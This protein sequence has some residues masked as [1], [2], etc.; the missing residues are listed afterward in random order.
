[1]IFVVVTL[2]GLG[3]SLHKTTYINIFEYIYMSDFMFLKC[4]Y[5]NEK[6]RL[7]QVQNKKIYIYILLQKTYSLI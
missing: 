2:T 7:V 1:M 6:N 4:I 5:N 3:S